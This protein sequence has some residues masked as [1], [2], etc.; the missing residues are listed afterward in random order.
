MKDNVNALNKVFLNSHHIP[1]HAIPKIG[2]SDFIDPSSAKSMYKR[3]IE[4]I[5][6]FEKNLPSDMQAGG[7]LVSFNGINFSIDNI[8]Y[9]NPDIII[10]YCS[11]STGNNMQLLQ[12]T[13]QLNLLLVAVPRKDDVSK[14]RRKIGFQLQSEDD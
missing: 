8:G 12:H 9:W 2:F 11:D 6:D 1:E 13:S 5:E 3:L 10:F 4:Q 14:P 7:R